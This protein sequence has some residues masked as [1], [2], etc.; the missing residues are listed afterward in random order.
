MYLRRS[1]LCLFLVAAIISATCQV[2]NNRAD[3]L[4]HLIANATEDSVRAE[5]LFDLS[6]LYSITQ[7][8]N[9]DSTSLYTA[10]GL[11]LSKRIG[12]RRGEI[13][14][15]Y[16]MSYV[17]VDRGKPD[18]AQG[19]LFAALEQLNKFCAQDLK[20]RLRVYNAFSVFY[21][22]SKPDS[23]IYYCTRMLQLATMTGDHFRE[24]LTYNNIAYEFLL[25]GNY[26][27]AMK[28]SIKGEEIAEKNNDL[29][30]KAHLYRRRGDIY[31]FQGNARQSALYFDKATA[32]TPYLGKVDAEE[33]LGL[34]H[35]SKARAY[36]QWNLLDS[37]LIFANEYYDISEKTNYHI[38]LTR[39][40]IVLGKIYE[41]MGRDSLAYDYFKRGISLSLRQHVV[42]SA[43]Q[44]YNSLA[45]YFYHKRQI[46]SCIAYAKRAV[47]IIHGSGFLLNEPE[48]YSILSKAYFAKKN[49]DSTF[50]YQQLTQDVKDSLLGLDK[51]EQIQLSVFEEEQNKKQQAADKVAYQERIRLYVL[52]SGIAALILVA[53]LLWRNNRTK[54]KAYRQLQAQKAATDL[55]KEKADKALKELRSTQ[56]QLIQSE[57]MASLGELT[58]GIA[59]EIQNPLNFVN[60]FSE[61]NKEIAD[62]L[63]TELRSGNVDQAIS[64]SNDIKENSEKISHHGKRADAIVK[65]MLQH[66]RSSTGAKEMID[67]NALAD[68]YLRLAY[69][70]VRAKDKNFNV[71]LKTNFDP[72]IG[73]INIV[74]QDIGRVLLNLYNN[75]LYAVNEKSKTAG[76]GINAGYKAVVS[77][78]TK[79][80]DNGLSIT[81]SDNGNGIPKSI[82]DKIFQPF[83]T[84]KPTG[85]GTGLGLSLSYDIIK[86]HGGEIKVESEIDEGNPNNFGKGVGCRFTVQLPA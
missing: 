61:V 32:L 40:M 2:E 11:E 48:T 37:A 54:Q 15:L 74:S 29:F 34:V 38:G 6:S 84:T 71:E 59:H 63:Q 31:F 83:F 86:A 30:L 57:K 67:I 85:H 52:L 20:L 26:P 76:S 4:Q 41:K 28:L 27:Q 73:K 53:G 66:S 39:M 72:T 64:L 55:Q 5:L 69:H 23:T 65:G 42:T 49:L 21:A 7:Y 18:I 35:L 19:L 46:D 68:E 12:N 70:G 1:F 47:D 75:A 14:G 78:T 50:K 56:A 58:A 81:V 8:Y 43:V 17:E 44:T 25:L 51:I 77:V 33:L 45:E 79:N 82:A 36:L 3:S 9:L 60:N 13:T 10:R 22:E 16:L 62:E 80:S 24:G